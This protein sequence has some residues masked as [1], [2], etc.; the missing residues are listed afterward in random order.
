MGNKLTAQG[1]HQ[2]LLP[3]YTDLTK[4]AP[5][6]VAKHRRSKIIDHTFTDMMSVDYN[7]RHPQPSTHYSHQEME[8]YLINDGDDVHIMNVI[9]AD[10]PKE[11]Y[12]SYIL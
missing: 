8:D 2:P 10:L 7:S 5:V 9:M 12:K 3:L 1:D 11:E 6:K 4:P